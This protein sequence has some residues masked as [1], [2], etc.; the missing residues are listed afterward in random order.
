LIL[1]S[2][3]WSSIGYHAQRN[4]KDDLLSL[5]FGF[6]E[7][8]IKN[9]EE[10]FAA[11]RAYVYEKGRLVDVE[12]SSSHLPGQLPLSDSEIFRYRTRY[13]V[14]SGIIGS[15]EFVRKHYL[16]F[17]DYFTTK[18][19]KQPRKVTGI[20]GMYSLKRLPEAL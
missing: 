10:R 7:F 18:H 11:Y 17:K 6:R 5:D 9:A 15:K 12:E 13:F 19:E 3:R 4:N 16:Q 2:Y 14:D 8:G 20:P 1:H